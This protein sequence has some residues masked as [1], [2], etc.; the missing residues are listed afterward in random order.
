MTSIKLKLFEFRKELSQDQ[1]DVANIISEHI[2]YCDQYSEKEISQS[3]NKVLEGF[4]Y[5]DNVKKLLNEFEQEINENSLY[6]TLKDIYAKIERKENRFLYEMALNSLLECINQPTDNERKVKVVETLSV[7]EWIPE[8]QIFLYEMAATPQEKMNLT[9]KGGKIDDVYSIA[10][11]ISEGFLVRVKDSWFLLSNEGVK[12][13]LL[14]TYVKDDTQLKKLRLL[15]QTL[16]VATFKG[17]SIEFDLTENCTLAINTGTGKMF[18]DSEELEKST[19]LESLFN[20]PVIPFAGKAQYPIIAE[21]LDSYKKFVILDN[22]KKVSNIINSAYESYIFNH[23]NKIYQYNVDKLSGSNTKE[24]PS[25]GSI[26]EN[27]M[28]EFGVDVTYFYEN[29]LSDEMKL[30]NDIEKKELKIQ[31]SLTN[32]DTAILKIKDQSQ[33]DKTILENA[34]IKKMYN[35]LLVTRHKLSEEVKSLRNKRSKLMA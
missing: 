34:S 10:L 11:Q 20:S 4:T 25:A 28:H 33:E 21:T 7:Y 8:I 19:T 3:L 23:S 29:L 35:E 2:N 27:V 31:E 12:G 18:L 26:I 14:E 32:I 6:F 15:E 17:N 9:S 5:F 16:N 22:V 1:F 13:V 24:W 30:R